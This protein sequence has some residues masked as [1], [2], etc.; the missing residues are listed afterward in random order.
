[1]YAYTKNEERKKNLRCLL[2]LHYD[3]LPT[4]YFQVLNRYVS[5]LIRVEL[6]RD[7][8]S[9]RLLYE[10]KFQQKLTCYTG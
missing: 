2:L 9:I 1:M 3:Y 5:T 4:R 8:F 7:K 10:R 6:K